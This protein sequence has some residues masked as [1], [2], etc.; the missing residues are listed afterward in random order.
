MT[1]NGLVP[2]STCS[3]RLYTKEPSSACQLQQPCSKAWL[4]CRKEEVRSMVDPVM[5]VWWCLRTAT[6]VGLFPVLLFSAS[7][8]GKSRHGWLYIMVFSVAMCGV[9]ILLT[10]L[11]NL[12]AHTSLPLD[13]E[14][15]PEAYGMLLLGGVAGPLAAICARRQRAF[16]AG[17]MQENSNSRE[18]SQRIES[19]LAEMSSGL[20]RVILFETGCENETGCGEDGTFDGAS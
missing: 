19:G 4:K 14:G 13:I 12:I 6:I 9:S 8:A 17:L 16:A 15:L 1:L 11:L 2:Q 20:T 5:V 18:N 7:R 3:T 10:T